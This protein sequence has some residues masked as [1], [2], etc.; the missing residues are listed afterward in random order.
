MIPII[1]FLAAQLVPS[2]Y[3]GAPMSDSP[4]SPLE[5]EQASFRSR[6]SLTGGREGKVLVV[7]A[8]Y[9]EEP[10]D[11]RLSRFA[12]DLAS[13]GWSVEVSVMEGGT[14]EDLRAL[15]QNTPDLDGAVLVGFLPCAWFEDD[16]WAP[17][18][19]PCELFFM[20]LNGSWGDSDSDGMYD[21]HTGDVAPEIWLGRIDASA[22]G[23]GNEIALLNGYFDK[24]H[25][26][27]TGSMAL[28]PGA[29]AFADDDW[30]EY[31][32]CGLEAV[33]GSQGV[34]VV[35]SP[36]QT[37][38]SEYLTRLGQGYEFVHLM[39]HSCPW[40]HTFLIPGG[41]GGTVMAPEISALAPQTAFYQL[42]S[43]SNA[44]WVE[45]GCLGNWY[46]FGTT[47]GLVVC[48]AAKTGSM[49]YFEEF[50]TPLGT[51]AAF[52]EAFRDWWQYVAQGGF[53]GYERAWFYGNALLGD[54]TLKPLGGGPTRAAMPGE[55]G[56][57]SYDPVSLSQYSDCHPHAA[58]GPG[59]MA[60]AAWLTGENGR[61]D[62][63][64]RVLEGDSWSQVYYV[65][66]DEYWDAGVSACFDGGGTPWLAWSDFEYAT[67][68]YRIKTAWGQAFENIQVRVPQEGYQVFP[69]L[70][71]DGSRM[72]LAW[73]NWKADGGVVMA[74]AL[75]GSF[76]AQSLSSS[77][78]FCAPPALAAEGG[79]VHAAWVE[80]SPSGSRVMY[81]AGNGEGFSPPVQVSS[82]TVCH[83]PD[84]LASGGQVLLVWQDATSGSSIRAR[85]MPGDE[86]QAAFTQEHAFRPKVS[87]LSGGGFAVYW[88][89]GYGADARIMACA[90]PG[91]E[92]FQPVSPE[93]PAWLP[94]PAG[95]MLFWAGNPGDGWDIYTGVPEWTGV[96]GSAGMPAMP[97]I[98]RN[99]VGDA[100]S[101]SLSP[102]S[103]PFTGAI[104]VFDLAGRMVLTR[105]LSLEPG[106]TAFI[107]LRGLPSGVYAVRTGD[108][109][110]VGRFTLIGN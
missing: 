57:E 26:Y 77:G 104:Q 54:P 55:L 99:P 59:G 20:D 16:Y 64:A 73:L 67:Y 63:A 50:Y 106:T 107:D 9:L 30:S 74:M 98:S 62:I 91:G 88:Q 90:L 24:N 15:L 34:T 80:T 4:R 41:H 94:C 95:D 60:V 87:S 93:G 58:A 5:S 71:W 42:F 45:S 17:E 27:R 31:S 28:N 3:S 83:D 52:G 96:E 84:L 72:W 92:P 51:G 6:A 35:N 46:I 66:S 82:G 8:G 36:A 38:A 103:G 100:V 75:D 65:D 85:F 29:L 70:A 40:G 47:T 68:S 19:F 11:F 21:S 61:L 78:V 23:Y 56:F 39:S 108:G 101:L 49:L 109:G 81:S 105:K 7:A 25:L 102:E 86:F 79:T 110:V 33:Y 69:R 48:G 53:S 22:M 13:E 32:T 14:A 44:R 2:G 76:P 43:C 97:V 89:E 12:A 10:L 37:T 18:E 1:L